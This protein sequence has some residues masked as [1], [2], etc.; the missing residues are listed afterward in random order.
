MTGS[1]KFLGWYVL[2]YNY[3]DKQSICQEKERI[4]QK[5]RSQCYFLSTAG[6]AAEIDQLFQVFIELT[7]FGRLL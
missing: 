1:N 3:I 6:V 4:G 5:I 2:Y 7:Q